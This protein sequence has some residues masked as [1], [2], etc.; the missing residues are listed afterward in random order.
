MRAGGG[1]GQNGPYAR[2]A[3][4]ARRREADAGTSALP[5]DLRVGK[6]TRR[7][8]RTRRQPLSLRSMGWHTAT[9]AVLRFPATGQASG[10][11]GAGRG[12]ESAGRA[13]HG[14]L[15][16][17]LH[18][19]PLGG[20]RC[21][22][23]TGD[24]SLWRP[25]PG[26]PP[27]RGGCRAKRGWGSTPCGIG[28]KEPKTTKINLEILRKIF[29]DFGGMDYAGRAAESARTGRMRDRPSLPGGAKRMR[30]PPRCR[31][32]SALERKRGGLA[33]RGGSPFA[34]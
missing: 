29:V 12:T 25:L 23:G 32:V 2:P 6:E 14:V 30:A 20:G 1:I 17:A 5:P 33:E 15:P 11:L 21:R 7:L 28:R 19:P 16:P 9:R 27:P 31:R 8:G 13:A 4:S 10:R 18:A 3:I 34:S 22:R 24:V 26:R